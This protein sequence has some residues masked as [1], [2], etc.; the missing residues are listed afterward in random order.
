MQGSME[1]P[2]QQSF[3]MGY[4]L[5][6]LQAHLPSLHPPICEINK[7]PSK[8]EPAQG[9]NLTLLYLSLL[10]FAIG[11]GCMRDCVPALGEDQFSNDDP[12][13]SHL[14]SNFLSWLKSANSLGALI[15]LVFLVWIEKNLGWD[16]GFLLCALIVIVGLLIAASGLPFYGMRKLN[17]SPLTRI[18]QVLVTSSKKR[19]AAVIHV[20]ELQEI[21][22]SDHVD[23]DGEDKCDSKNI[24]TTRVD[25]KTEAITRMLP[26]FISCIFAY[27]PFT[28]LMTLTIQVGSTMDSGIGMIQIP[29][30][31]LIAI[32]TTF[33]M[34]MQPCYRRILI[35]LLRIFT[36]HTNGITPLQHIGVASACGIMAACIAMLVEAKRLMVVEQQGLTLVADGVPMSVFWLVM[37]FFLLSIMDIAYIG[38]LVQFIKS[39]AP[40]AKHIAPAVQS[41]LVGIAAWSGCAFVQLVN[42]MTRLGDNGRGWLDGTNFNRTR[43]DRFFLLLAT[44]E[45]VA[46]INYAFWARRYANKKRVSTVRSDGDN[47]GA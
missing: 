38:G 19:Q 29:S 47:F 44:F 34:L 3:S 30:A 13:A 2:R 7:D 33:H 18:L 25:E 23:E 41:L 35:P 12:E 21:S 4:M 15:G 26:I 39:E 36:G 1:A 6:A 11:E 8:C 27:L 24:C 14:R 22:T 28:L 37:Q 31:S 17:G 32:P 5:L 9:W 40:E 20:I 42:R 45:L 10:M 16:I 46:F 43:L